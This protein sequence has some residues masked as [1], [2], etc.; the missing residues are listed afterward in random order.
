MPGAIQE[1]AVFGVPLAFLWLSFMIELTPGPNMTYLA[2]LTL[3]GAQVS[4]LLP[5]SPPVFF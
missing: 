4:R 2:V 1:L 3:A 5:V